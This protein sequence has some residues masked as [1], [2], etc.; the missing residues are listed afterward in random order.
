MDRYFS[1]GNDSFGLK[2]NKLNKNI[3]VYDLIWGRNGK[4]V[5]CGTRHNLSLND[6]DNMLNCD[7]I[8]TITRTLNCVNYNY[9]KLN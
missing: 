5:H 2:Y 7:Q 6:W 9:E 4:P 8:T 3:E 1:H